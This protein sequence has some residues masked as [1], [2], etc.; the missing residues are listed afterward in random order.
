MIYYKVKPEGHQ[1][2][3][4]PMDRDT[5]CLVAGELF[6]LGEIR[7]AV[8]RKR[9]DHSFVQKYM[10]AVN[11]RPKDTYRSFGVRKH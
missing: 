2:T 11:V 4:A 6:T 9:F 1:L 7:V 10:V 8:N 5:T 3:P